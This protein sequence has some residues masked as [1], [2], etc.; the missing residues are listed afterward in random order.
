MPDDASALLAIGIM[1]AIVWATR[2]C[3]FALAGWLVR[4]PLAQR[5]LQ[6]LPGCAFAAILAPAVV[7]G[8][9]TDMV[10]LV[11]AL[12]LF[13]LTGRVMASVALGI[14]LLVLGAHLFPTAPA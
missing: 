6:G 13:Q 12:G 7:R 9:A 8:S 2:L 1:G 14:A 11:A 10:A 5:V 4:G 3:G